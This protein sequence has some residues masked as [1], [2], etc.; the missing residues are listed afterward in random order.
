M[1]HN[2]ALL[3]NGDEIDLIQT[4]TKDTIEILGDYDFT[5]NRKAV[6]DRYIK[7]CDD[8]GVP[9]E[10]IEYIK[11]RYNQAILDQDRIQFCMS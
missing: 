7:W 3:I 11:Q 6:L 4:P 10:H 5:N 1:S 9:E 2:L 8:M